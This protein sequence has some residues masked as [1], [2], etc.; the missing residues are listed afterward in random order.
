MKPNDIFL[1]AIA[2]SV[3]IVIVSMGAG[4]GYLLFSMAKDLVKGMT[5]DG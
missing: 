5:R 1:Y 4:T 3:S 2:L